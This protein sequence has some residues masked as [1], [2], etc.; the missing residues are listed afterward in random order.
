MAKKSYIWM[1]SDKVFAEMC[2]NC[3]G[4]NGV[5][6]K[7]RRRKPYVFMISQK[8]SEKGGQSPQ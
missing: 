4:Q 8:N 5:G 6:V 1:D 2:E 3:H 7:S